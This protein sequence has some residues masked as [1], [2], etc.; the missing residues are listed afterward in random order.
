MHSKACPRH[1]HPSPTTHHPPHITHH[2]SPITTQTARR[3]REASKATAGCSAPFLMSVS[4]QCWESPATLPS[5]HAAC[6]ATTGA[7]TRSS[8]IRCGAARSTMA[9]CS[10]VPVA[11]L[12]R[13]LPT[14][15]TKAQQPQQQR[16]VGGDETDVVKVKG[17]HE[18]RQAKRFTGAR[19][20]ACMTRHVPARFQLRFV[21]ATHQGVHQR[22]HDAGTQHRLCAHQGTT[23][24]TLSHVWTHT[25]MHG[26][27]TPIHRSCERWWW[28]RDGL[29]LCSSTHARTVMGGSSAINTRRRVLSDARRS[30][31]ALVWRR[32]IATGEA[33]HSG[34]VGGWVGAAQTQCNACDVRV[35]VWAVRMS[36]PR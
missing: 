28:M 4:R 9:V 6:S 14:H 24:P 17:S 16:A 27:R 3:T 22:S 1:H 11:M 5:A 12:A 33:R 34:W 29:R 18:T 32:T 25:S 26:A 19:T 8:A 35:C 2:P 7:C 23:Q 10:S 15:H 13:H 31:G 21:R 36:A 20:H 30:A